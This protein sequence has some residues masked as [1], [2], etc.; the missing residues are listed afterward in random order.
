MIAVATAGF[1]PSLVNTA[2]RRAPVSA[3]AAAHGIIFCIWLGIFLVQ[4]RLIAGR[5]I[6]THRRIGI[7]AGCVAAL[8]ISLGYATC[9]SMARR[10][11]DL[12]G[13]LR[14]ERDPAYLVIFPLGDLFMFAV[15]ITAA[16]ACRRQPDMH[17][18]LMLLANVA[19]IP[20]PLAHLIGHVSWLAAMPGMIILIPISLFLLA[21]IGREFLVDG[22]AHP[23]TWGIAAAMLISGPLRAAVV[24][25]SAA[26]HRFIYW[27]CR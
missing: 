11:F 24:G 27:L 18:R 13:D 6:T 4:A 26:W 21:A 19:L 9:I 23:L 5:Q 15:L 16:I 17:K 3:L 22:R 1:L 14:A 12:S 10:G 7:A 8:M 2:G 25:P 20:A